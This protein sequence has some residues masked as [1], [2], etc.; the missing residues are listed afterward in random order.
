MITVDLWLLGFLVIPA[1]SVFFCRVLRL[2]QGE[3][4]E[5]IVFGVFTGLIL[6]L[7]YG[8]VLL[9]FRKRK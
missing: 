5:E 7:L 4:A 8:I 1:L 2:A 6:D 9:Y 3:R